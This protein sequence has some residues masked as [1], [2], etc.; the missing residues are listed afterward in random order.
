[1]KTLRAFSLGLA[2]VLTATSIAAAEP[3]DARI[4]D[5]FDPDHRVSQPDLGAIKS[6]RFLTTDDYPPFHF[7]LPDGTLTGFD[8]D[9]ARAI[10]RDLK[11]ACTIQAR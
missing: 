6:I 7:T 11:L 5:L 4:P 10:C 1:M 9:L 2:T 8:I 3:L